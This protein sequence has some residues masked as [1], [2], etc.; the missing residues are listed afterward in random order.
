M[1]KYYLKHRSLPFPAV[2]KMVYSIAS[3]TSTCQTITRPLGEFVRNIREMTEGLMDDSS[4]HRNV[5]GSLINR[6]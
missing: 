6:C 4:R 3:D 2:L 5:I 1:Q